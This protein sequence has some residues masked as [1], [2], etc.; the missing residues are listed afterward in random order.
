MT[1]LPHSCPSCGQ[2]MVIVK[3][4]CPDCGTEVSGEFNLCPVCKL[5]EEFHKLFDTFL[6]ARGNLK[7]VQRELKVSYPTVRARIDKLF[8]ELDKKREIPPAKD[9]LKKL[10][11]GEINV[12]EAENLLRNH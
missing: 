3:L 8:F 12:D 7:Q 1:T 11:Q 5:D 6:R 9:I 10:R 4:S 2:T